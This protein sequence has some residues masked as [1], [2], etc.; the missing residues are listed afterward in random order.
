MTVHT[1]LHVILCF[2][3]SRNADDGSKHHCVIV[4]SQSCQHDN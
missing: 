3:V 2:M 1:F 4:L